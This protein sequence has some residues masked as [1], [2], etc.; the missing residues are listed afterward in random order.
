MCMNVIFNKLPEFDQLQILPLADLH[1][2]DIHSDG[3]KINEWLAYI[4]DTENCY[5]I[6]N[7][8]LMDTAIKTS[9]GDT[10][11]AT[12]QPMQQLQQCVKIFEPIKDKILAVTAGNHEARIYKTDGLDTTQL[13]CNQLGIPEK[14]SPASVLIFVQ[15]GRQSGYKKY[16]P[17]TY[18]LYCAHGTGGGRKEGGKIN[19][20]VELASIIDADIYIH[21][22]THTPAIIRNGY[23]RT[24][25]AGHSVKKV[26]RLFVNTSA[27]LDYGG[28]GEFQNYK[29]NSL[30][31][32]LIF[33]DGHKRDMKA[34]L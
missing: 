9:I 25:I 6:L 33:L 21:S 23:Y 1:I 28:Y 20:L 4:R 30:E 10:Y 14:Y 29:P 31:T 15:F 5:T 2:G 27:S 32:P 8:D 16:W 3:K 13:M 12:L 26:D 19:R 24:F 18:T 11:G 22:H 34:I 17:M 7:G